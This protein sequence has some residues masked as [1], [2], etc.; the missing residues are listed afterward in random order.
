MLSHVTQGGLGYGIDLMTVSE[1]KRL[2]EQTTWV[3][4]YFFS[5]SELAICD[6]WDSHRRLEFLAGRFSAKESLQKALFSFLGRRARVRPSDISII[7]ASD[8]RPI[9]QWNPVELEPHNVCIALSISHKQDI[10]VSAALLYQ[11][12][13][14]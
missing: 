10:C 9:V 1:L 14:K 4:D 2:L 7:R 6:S 13:C 12:Q 11:Q 3:R 5:P 8:R